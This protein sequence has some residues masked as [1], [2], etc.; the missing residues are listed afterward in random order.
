MYY[1]LWILLGECWNSSWYWKMWVGETRLSFFLYLVNHTTVMKFAWW[2]FQYWAE[3]SL[4]YP[5]YFLT[6]VSSSTIDYVKSFLE[7]M[8]DSITKSFETSRDNAFLLKYVALFMYFL[9]LYFH[10]LY[11]YQ[12]SCYLGFSFLLSAIKCKNMLTILNP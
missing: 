7:W 4:N 10:I 11:G 3:H 1:F 8:G 2:N 6:Y 5:I 12:F 9:F